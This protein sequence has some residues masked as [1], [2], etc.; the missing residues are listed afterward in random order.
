M[1]KTF[2][3]TVSLIDGMHFRGENHRGNAVDMDSKPE[4][5]ETAGATPM[6]LV[7]QAAGACSAMDVAF[8]LRKRR[9]PPEILE[10]YIE[11]VKRDEHPRYWKKID[12]TYRAKGE[13]ITI[14]EL[15][16]AAELSMKTYC[17]VFGMLQQ[18]AE[19]NFT[20]EIIE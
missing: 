12:A 2:K 5:E 1:G 13:G 3:A 6:E 8:I 11:G 16:R 10:V 9:K 20:C 7:L 17:A 19:I 15:Q 14:E 18:V 4:G